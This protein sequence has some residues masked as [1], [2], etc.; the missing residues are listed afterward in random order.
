MFKTKRAR[1]KGGRLTHPC[2]HSQLK[3]GD[4]SVKK[5]ISYLNEIKFR[6]V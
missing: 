3:Y 4:C 6:P 1:L 2:S 5:R